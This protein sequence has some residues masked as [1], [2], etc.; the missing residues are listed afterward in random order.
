MIVE[1]LPSTFS[2]LLNSET[3]NFRVVD[4]VV[5]PVIEVSLRGEEINFEIF[6]EKKIRGSTRRLFT[7]SNE[8]EWCYDDKSIY[9]FPRG[10][11]DQLKQKLEVESLAELSQ[12]NLNLLRQDLSTD[13][14]FRFDKTMLLS[15]NDLC[16]SYAVERNVDGLNATLF[17]YQRRGVEWLFSKSKYEKGALVADEMGLGKTIQVLGFLAKIKSDLCKKILIVC[18]T[19]LKTNWER[20]IEKF[21]P[22]FRTL[23]HEGKTRAGISRDFQNYD[24]IIVN[25]ETL[26][27]DIT[28]FRDM[29]LSV[30][31]VDEAQAIK[32]PESL[33][34]SAICSL[35]RDFSIAITGTPVETSL[36]DIWSIF[37]F[38]NEG[39]L[40]NQKSF[41][42]D[43]PDNSQA[44]AELQKTIAPLMINRKVKEVA[45]DLPER[46]D[47]NLPVQFEDREKEKYEELR[48]AILDK[49][50]VSGGLVA[51]TYL[52]LYCCHPWLS[53]AAEFN[54]I[55]E[56]AV[57]PSQDDSLVTSKLEAISFLLKEAI[58]NRKKV[59][60]FCAFNNLL[61]ILKLFIPELSNGY[62]NQINGSVPS[63]DRQKIIDEFTNFEGFGLLLLNPKA[64][65]AGL[66]IT[67]ATI[68]IHYS[69]YWNPAL[70]AQASA[71]AYRRGQTQTVYIYRLFYE[72]TVEQIM[73]E[74]S[75]EREEM[76]TEIL[77]SEEKSQN[78]FVKALQISPMD[79]V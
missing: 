28:L 12:I 9:P 29:D 67:T 69:P 66:N 5:E 44:A 26:V 51:T 63:R 56:A 45:G 35:K 54:E 1:D 57:V 59:L 71:R 18:P 33:R 79:K 3:I 55:E 65:G 61:E 46:I 38:A 25:Y 17:D 48:Q 42:E 32:N 75:L 37:N 15:G 34:H 64:A 62:M 27:N 52:Q 8:H 7:V 13:F 23:T 30:V 68:V 43:Y 72:N 24:I 4:Q 50:P 78:D 53:Q 36:L 76:G 49:Y 58:Y 77:I 2:E 10:F 41:T 39:F 20:E 6:A 21:T 40:P 16:G 74:R 60:V 70:E 19:S 14:N 31:I 11:I 73:L 47:I 22:N